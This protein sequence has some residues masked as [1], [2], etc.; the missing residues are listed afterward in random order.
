MIQ[1]QYE[2]VATAKAAINGLT[3]KASYIAGGTNLVDLMKRRIAAPSK[4]IDINAVPLKDIQQ[5]NGKIELMEK[6]KLLER[7][8]F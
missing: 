4:L 8:R 3:T 7:Y 5:Q 1:F 2:R 6:T